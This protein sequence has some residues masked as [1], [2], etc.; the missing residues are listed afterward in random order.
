MLLLVSKGGEIVIEILRK[1]KLKR[2]IRNLE[3]GIENLSDEIDY[4]NFRINDLEYRV[5]LFLS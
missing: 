5:D 1:R 2:L 3:I 4:L